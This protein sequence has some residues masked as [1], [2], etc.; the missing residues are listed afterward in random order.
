MDISLVSLLTKILI[1]GLLAMSL[2]LVFGYVGL[3][4]FAHA[5]LF[6]VSAYAA[7]IFVIHYHITSFWIVLPGGMFVAGIVAGIFGFIALRVSAIYFLLITL[8]LGQLVF[9]I[10][11]TFRRLTGGSNGLAGIQYPD[12]TF[13]FLPAALSST[14]FY[15]LTLIIF[16]VC[17]FV[18]YTLLN[19]PFG[20]SLRGIRE[21][22]SRMRGL[23]YNTWLIKF[24]AFIVSGLFAGVAGVLYVHFNGIIAPGDVGVMASGAVMLMVIIGGA[25]TLW[26]ALIGSV[27]ILSLQHFIGLIIPERWPL[28][29][30]IC[31]ALVVICLR[32]G[33]FPY[34]HILWRKVSSCES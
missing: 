12:L 13:P 15:Y 5:A 8:A 28:V 30:G 3:W 18:L 19:S 23:G 25:G 10:V 27:V 2:D 21:N 9:G 24:T 6:G 7:A 34:L 16:V 26:G 29:M 32:G 31:F 4:S 33:I 14:G 11:T 20:Y 22:E 17:A 1:F